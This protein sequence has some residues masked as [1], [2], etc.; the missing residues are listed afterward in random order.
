LENIL[1]INKY[2]VVSIALQNIIESISTNIKATTIC[3]VGDVLC[4]LPKIKYDAIIVTYHEKDTA[5]RR[6]IELLSHQYGAKMIILYDNIDPLEFK[7]WDTWHDI[8]YLSMGSEISEIKASIR[9]LLKNHVHI[10]YT[11]DVN[12]VDATV[13]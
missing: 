7:K 3:N 13:Y 5:E 10:P 4:L 1:I 12:I 9:R 11:K 8:K 6:S 2:I